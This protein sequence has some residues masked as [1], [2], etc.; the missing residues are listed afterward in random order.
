[1]SKKPMTVCFVL[2]GDSEDG[3]SL[4]VVVGLGRTSRRRLRVRAKCLAKAHGVF[5][6]LFGVYHTTKTV[7]VLPDTYL[8]V[9][10]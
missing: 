9:M 1:M 4:I 7:E 5:R 3:N 6:P 2:A 10:A 8:E